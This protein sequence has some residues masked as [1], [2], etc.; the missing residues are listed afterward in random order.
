MTVGLSFQES[1]FIWFVFIF[2][3]L[4]VFF[5]LAPISG[6]KQIPTLFRLGFA[7][8]FAFLIWSILPDPAP[9]KETSLFL[10]SAR[11]FLIAFSGAFLLKLSLACLTGFI[12]AGTSSLG[13]QYAPFL[14]G[15]QQSQLN[16]LSLLWQQMCLQLFLLTN[17]H[18]IILKTLV[19]SFQQDPWGLSFSLESASSILSFFS[20]FL[21]QGLRLAWPF[22]L[23]QLLSSFIFSVFGRLFSKVQIFQLNF[24]F[25]ILAALSLSFLS[26]GSMV[27]ALK[28]QIFPHLLNQLTT[29]FL[30][31]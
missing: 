23:F 12:H 11:E 8:T 10:L 3:R 30:Q 9:L 21:S 1:S 31:R 16:G 4:G 19:M 20:Y 27:V 13:L 5:Y 28:G 2:F 25:N 22:F 15:D 29:F 24:P 6:E 7:L 26:Y 17:S 14:T 18:H